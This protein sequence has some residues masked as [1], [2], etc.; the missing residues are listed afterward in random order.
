MVKKKKKRKYKRSAPTMGDVIAIKLKKNDY[1][2]LEKYR[3]EIGMSR[4]A[5]F[6]MLFIDFDKNHKND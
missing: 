3:L 6:R 1:E 5:F 4:S 2:K